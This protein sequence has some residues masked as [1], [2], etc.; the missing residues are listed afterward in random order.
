VDVNH[1][2]RARDNCV[3]KSLDG[4]AATANPNTICNGCIRNLQTQLGQLPHLRDALESFKRPSLVGE[5]GSKVS[6]TA[7][8]PAPVNLTVVDL[9]IEIWRVVSRAGGP[10]V[11]IRNLVTEPAE[12]F[13]VW[14]SGRYCERM[15]DGADRALDV[16]AVWRKADRI[17]GLSRTWEKRR[18]APCPRCGLAG[19]GGWLGEGTIHCTNHSCATSFSLSEYEKLCIAKVELDKIEKKEKK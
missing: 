13:S 5:L 4:P 9:I 11:Q 19:L 10:E 3:G 15:L 16:G 18:G 17:V 1:R 12:P 7:T 2:C 14:R 8:P 6:A